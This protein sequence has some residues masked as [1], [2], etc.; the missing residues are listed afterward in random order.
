MTN[1]SKESNTTFKNKKFIIKVLIV[2]ILFCAGVTCAYFSFPIISIAI[3]MI[4][5]GL[6]N[7]W[8]ILYH[9]Y[10]SNTTIQFSRKSKQSLI[11]II[12]ISIGIAI[13]AAYGVSVTE[14]GVAGIF[15]SLVM[16]T[17]MI[18]V[19][20][21]VGIIYEWFIKKFNHQDI[22]PLTK[23]SIFVRGAISYLG[24]VLFQRLA[25][26]QNEPIGDFLKSIFTCN[27]KQISN[28]ISVLILYITLT[29]ISVLLLFMV[30]KSTSKTR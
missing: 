17:G 29:I 7:V 23:T 20:F 8:K 24:L 18:A 6:A 22:Y 9:N 5:F 3:L 10:S 2:L 1:N 12:I 28:E 19:S 15:N 13:S 4:A 21:S 27:D 26:K 25:S 11:L 30:D 16:I 14:L